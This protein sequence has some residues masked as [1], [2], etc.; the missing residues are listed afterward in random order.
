MIAD[1]F[2]GGAFAVI[3]IAAL[4]P[5]LVYSDRRKRRRRLRLAAG[6]LTRCHCGT[7]F[8]NLYAAYHHAHTAHGETEDAAR[9]TWSQP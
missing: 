9:F 2:A 3:L 8:R 1:I 5:L 6:A 7:T 4:F